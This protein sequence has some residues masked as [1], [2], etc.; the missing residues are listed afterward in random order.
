MTDL[1]RRGFVM[2]SIISGL[3]LAT[4]RVEAQ[5][6]HTSTAGLQAGEVQVP[7]SDGHLPAYAARPDGA[8]P[9]PIVLVVE[10]VFGVHE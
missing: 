7:V 1:P 8:G 6:I 5:A 4:T 10:E 2:T 3:T 9:F